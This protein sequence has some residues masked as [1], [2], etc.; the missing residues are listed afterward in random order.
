MT[1]I[2]FGSISTLADTSEMQ[3][4]AFNDAFAKHDLGWTWSR[5]DYASMLGGNGGASRIADYAASKNQ[6]VDS[7]AVHST[8]SE[9]FR[10]LLATEGIEPRPGVLDTMAKARE[11]G[12]KLGLVTTT[13]PENVSALL[14]SFETLSADSFDV[15]VDTTAVSQVKPDPASYLFAVDSLGEDAAH[16]VAI[17][18][19]EGGVASAA[20][21]SIRC[22][23]FP[24]ANT[25]GGD[26][27]AAEEVVDRL[28]PN[29]LSTL[30]EGDNA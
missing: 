3:R 26:F 30:A 20:A 24:N 28:D 5:E 25:T 6:E 15:V 8:K 10:T 23:A 7:A 2:L 9:I 21:A 11:H 18:D 22:V 16:C 12:F 4:R 1:A 14:D 27:S 19:N 13:S 17:E 29:R